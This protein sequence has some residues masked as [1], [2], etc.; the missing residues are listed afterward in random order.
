MLEHNKI[1]Q[2]LIA[3]D[4]ASDD[5]E[6]RRI[7]AT[8]S[9]E[10]DL[11]VPADPYSDEY[12]K[13]QFDLYERLAKKTYTPQNEVTLFDVQSAAISPFPYCHG[14]CDTVGNQ[15]MAIGFVIKALQLPK[16]AKILEFGFGWGNTTIAL[17]KMGFD[18]TAIDIEK[19]FCDLV[20][21]RAL[22]EKLNITIIHSDFNYIKTIDTQ[23]D[24]ILFFECFH[25]ADNHLEL[26]AEFDRVIKPGGCVCFGAE[27]IM[28]EFPLPW[29]LRMDGESLWAIS[30]NGWLELG[31]NR[32]YFEN[33]MNRF[34]WGLTFHKGVDGPWSSAIIA[35]RQYEQG[36]EYSYHSGELKTQVGSVNENGDILTTGVEGYLIYG[37]YI[38]LTNGSWRAEF[39]CDQDTEKSGHIV[40]D[41]ACF[42]GVKIVATQQIELAK[43][44]LKATM[45]IDFFLEEASEGVEIR[46]YVFAGTRLGIKQLK[47]AP[48]N[49]V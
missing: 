2:F 14:S 5:D 13:K 4:N 35:Q 11:N 25:H 7:F 1:D 42:G 6:L 3:L 10:Y 28:P 34:G 37:P 33:T 19:N 44:T 16:G 17:A 24:A 41:V 40:M 39:I 21:E 32:S 43:Q 49:P 46:I 20:E 45:T 12:R 27:P 8:Y 48:F 26:I 38:Q 29:G 47:L 23:F 36:G 22:L 15:L 9:A 30:K 18:V 31:Y